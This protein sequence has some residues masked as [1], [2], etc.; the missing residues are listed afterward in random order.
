MRSQMGLVSQDPFIFA[1]TIADNIRFGKPE[2]TTREVIAAGEL[3]NVGEFVERP[4]AWLRDRDLRRRRQSI[5]RAAATDFDRARH[6]GRPAH[7][8]YG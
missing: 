4:A 8:D 1:G 3:A 7:P 6:P 5:S 2:A